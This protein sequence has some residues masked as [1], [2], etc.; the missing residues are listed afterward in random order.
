MKTFKK[1]GAIFLF[2][3]EKFSDKFVVI[4]NTL[5]YCCVC[6]LDTQIIVI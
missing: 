1:N 3:I 5:A 2:Q 6:C 4:D